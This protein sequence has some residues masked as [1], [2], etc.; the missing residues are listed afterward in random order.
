MSRHQISSKP[1]LLTLGND[2]RAEDLSTSEMISNSSVL[3]HA[4][5]DQGGSLR[6]QPLTMWEW[7]EVLDIGKAI[8]REK[9]ESRCTSP[10]ALFLPST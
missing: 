8:L 4:V 2:L 3:H 6:P 9:T 1:V 10:V 5:E 7:T